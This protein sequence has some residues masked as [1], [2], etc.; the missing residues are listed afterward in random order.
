MLNKPVGAVV[1]VLRRGILNPPV[2]AVVAAGVVPNE[3]PVD[4][5]NPPLSP[6]NE[7]AVEE[8]LNVSPSPNDVVTAEEFGFLVEHATHSFADSLLVIRHTSHDQL[9]LGGARRSRILEL[10]WANCSVLCSSSC[11]TL[12]LSLLASVFKLALSLDGSLNPTNGVASFP[13]GNNL[14]VLIG[15]KDSQAT[16]FNESFWLTNK[17]VS[18]DQTSFE[19]VKFDSPESGGFG[20]VDILL[21]GKPTVGP[22]DRAV[23]LVVVVLDSLNPPVGNPPLGA[24]VGK[25]S[26]NPPVGAVV[27]V[28]RRGSLNPPVGAVVA[29]GVVPNERPV[30]NLNPPLSPNDNE[31]AVEVVPPSPNDVEVALTA[32]EFGFLVEHATHSFADSLLVTRHTSHDQ[33]PLGGARRPRISELVWPSCLVS[34][35]SSCV[36]LLLSLLVSVL[37]SSSTANSTVC[38]NFVAISSV[39]NLMASF[40]DLIS[41]SENSALVNQHN[42]RLLSCKY[43]NF[44]AGTT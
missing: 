22:L 25:V 26:F 4:N 8:V 12:L 10:V 5:L 34:R 32:A 39:L 31:V 40:S 24:V 20:F 35:S 13:E 43:L 37:L 3:S 36:E 44:M 15:L 42:I 2:G 23:T 11:I 41:S 7:V 30:D 21:R 38:L 27:A 28:L 19:G 1:A 33:L 29:A 18:H 9:P 16:H 17:Q 6:N 14:L